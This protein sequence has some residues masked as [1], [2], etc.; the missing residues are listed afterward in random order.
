VRKILDTT[1][2][3]GPHGPIMQEIPGSEFSM[4]V[5]MVLLAMGFLHVSH[6]SIVK[7][8]DL[9]LDA[10]G[11]VKVDNRFMTSQEGIFAAGDAVTG[12]SF[13]AYAINLGRI[14]AEQIDYYLRT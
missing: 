2:S 12:S 7:Q 13:V 10:R 8:F 11:N 14:V 1:W 4:R 6:D 3:N 9:N 5:D